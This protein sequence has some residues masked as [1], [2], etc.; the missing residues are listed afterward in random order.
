MP[1]HQTFL[2]FNSGE[3][4][5]YLLYR[6]D[7][8]K[9]PGGAERMRNFLPLPF[10][11]VSKRP[12]TVWK[13]ETEPGGLNS[14]AFPFTSSNGTHYVLHFTQEL[15][16]VYRLDGTV[17]DTV[18]FLT[19]YTFPD[20]A[21]H[22]FSI[23]GMQMV[24]VNDVA[25]F[26]HPAFHPLR[27]VSVSDTVWELG[28]LPFERA[29]TLDENLDQTKTY[30]VAS[31][32]VAPTWARGANYGAG[33]SV[34]TNSEWVCIAAHTAGEANRPGVGASWK[35]FWKR[36]FFEAGD[37]ITLLSE[38]R[39]EVAWALNYRRFE[40]GT[41]VLRE[42]GNRPL[43][44]SNAFYVCRISHL[45]DE[46][47][48]GAGLDNYADD[49]PTVLGGPRVTG[50]PWGWVFEY[51]PAVSSG[52]YQIG[53]LAFYSGKIYRCLAVHAVDGGLGV[54]VPEETPG[55]TAYWAVEFASYNA[56]PSA[57][58]LIDE[59]TAGTRVSHE[60]RI[61]NC[62]TTHTPSTENRPGVGS[63]WTLVVDGYSTA[64]AS[65]VRSPGKYYQI[66]PE[67]DE[68]DFQ[69]ELA[70]WSGNNGR[71]SP[72]I[73][74][75]GGWNV[76]T[77]GTWNGTFTVQRSVNGGKTWETIRSYQSS[78]DRNVSDTG[79]EDVPTLMR[80]G[81]THGANG[82]SKPRALLIPESNSV[83]GYA[84]VD[85]Y[86][87]TTRMT[88]VAKTSMLSGN[89][90]HWAEGAF[91]INQGFPRAITLHGFRL[92]FASTILNPVSVWASR[93]NSF[94]D[95]ETG[96][97]DDHGIFRTLAES[98]HRPI[99]WLASTR[100][101]F[102]G[103]ST[104]EWV[105]G[106]ET[107]DNPIT[108]A[109]VQFREYNPTGSAPHQ[110][111]Q[112]HDGIFF[113]GRQGGRLYEL[114]ASEAGND[115]YAAADLSILAEHL[116]QPGVHSLAY[117]QTRNPCLWAVTNPG[118]LLS[119]NYSR[120]HNVSAW[121]MH[122]TQAGLFRDVMV[123]PS[124][125]GDDE[126]FF[127]IDRGD[128]SN[129][130]RFPQGWQAAQEAGT[131]SNF[132]DAEGMEDGDFPIVSELRVPPQDMQLDGGG[133]Q[134]RRKRANEILLNVFQSF[135]GGVSYDGQP[136]TFNYLSTSSNMDSPLPLATG[137][138]GATLPPGFMDDL[139]FTISHSD[140][141]PF[142]VRAAVLRWS[143]HE[144]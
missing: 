33:A 119:F 68:K 3:L 99:R 52:G 2:S 16:T 42:F 135:G 110:P 63:V 108:P 61:Y 6:S 43:G 7:F 10:G 4:S 95:F 84:L 113:L 81:Y 13:A 67:R 139:Q 17:A 87:N 132:V 29:P 24:Q 8:A 28:F 100:R 72:E 91:D 59:Y 125:D 76:F 15:L 79:S 97:D 9:V 73:V 54:F 32:P 124:D 109:N 46:S 47:F 66:S 137:W 80:L 144:P 34:F 105:E 83:T 19:G 22:E 27:L 86:V 116:T 35:S 12:G 111:L 50:L 44:I 37:A 88:G 142:T 123:F 14:K 21:T 118:A 143:L 53:E 18:P 114:G 75:E 36:A 85:T 98:N 82:S 102:L 117:Q 60:G 130:E 5:P 49:R 89:T 92:W 65:S 126:V 115:T 122:T 103:T 112:V 30:T 11:S 62:N 48:S 74:V 31:N 26:T 134:G 136:T 90:Y 104:S 121:A 23:R 41:T 101:L 25:F 1:I 45:T 55:W 96:T 141:A 127:I 38:N 51:I 120:S 106:S 40:P 69:V 64:F 131:L 58:V 20:D 71:T 94:F 77:F 140:P 107:S 129:L 133:T 57:I 93:I 70:A 39:S 138:I 128:T 78:A 56:T